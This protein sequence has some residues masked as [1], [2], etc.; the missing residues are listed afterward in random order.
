[1]VR[2]GS[3]SWEDGESLCPFV[4]PFTIYEEMQDGSAV[5]GSTTIESQAR[6]IGRDGNQSRTVDVATRDFALRVVDAL[7]VGGVFIRGSDNICSE[8]RKRGG[9]MNRPTI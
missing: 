1:M 3:E 2:H 6:V 8:T 9:N 7:S 4:T 5:P